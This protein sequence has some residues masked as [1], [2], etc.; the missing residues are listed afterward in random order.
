MTLEERIAEAKRESLEHAAQL[1]EARAS[2]HEQDGGHLRPCDAAVAAIL[3][4]MARKVRA[5]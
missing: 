1:L 4:E 2:L 3:R 5:P